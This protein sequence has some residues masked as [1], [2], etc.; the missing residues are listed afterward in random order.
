MA[1][2]PIHADGSTLLLQSNSKIVFNTLSAFGQTGMVDTRVRLQQGKI[3][4]SVQPLRTPDS[5]FEIT[6]PAAVAAV[7]GTDFRVSYEESKESMTSGVVKGNIKVAAGN[8]EVDVKQG[9]GT[10]TKKGEA[11]KPPTRLLNKPVTKSLQKFIVSLPYTFSWPNLKDAAQYR[12]QLSAIGTNTLL[13]DSVRQESTFTLTHLTDGHYKL[14]VRGI[15]KIGLEGFNAEHTFQLDTSIKEVELLTPDNHINTSDSN[16]QLTWKHQQKASKY[17]LQISSDTDFTDPVVDQVLD[18][19]Q[20]QTQD[21]LDTGEY[22]WRVAGIDKNN[23]QG[24]FSGNR[25]ITI[26]E[27]EYDGMMLILYLLPIFFL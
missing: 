16:I 11:P 7:R 15:D 3:E 21:K 17:H 26:T 22:Y 19:T 18:S 8:V 23:Q 10:V 14:R 24:P 27:E 2:S 1:K 4:T 25:H 9:F 6:T 5:R 13:E 20:F 12:I